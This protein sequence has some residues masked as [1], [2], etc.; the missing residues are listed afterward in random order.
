M[1][2]RW[3]Y[4]QEKHPAYCTCIRC[5]NSERAGNAHRSKTAL[6]DVLDRWRKRDLDSHY[7]L[8]VPPNSSRDLIVEAHRRWIVAYHPD[9]HQNDPRA[10]ELTKRLN[11]A[12]DELLGKGRRAS[13][14]QREQR[15]S[16][17]EAER[18][19][20]RESERRS[21]EEAQRQRANKAEQQRRQEEARQQGVNEAERLLRDAERRRQNTR[22]YAQQV[23]HEQ[24][25]RSRVWVLLAITLVTI[26]TGYLFVAVENPESVDS[27][28]NEWASLFDE[29]LARK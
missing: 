8:G 2:D 1:A 14:S 20:T 7:I 18:Q 4:A 15:Q 28:M 10:T 6:S 22:S 3:Q 13:Q 19:R 27:L 17:E 25:K 29:A 9:K 11:A 21:Q 16:Q 26:I 23:W 24:P 5:V 12:R